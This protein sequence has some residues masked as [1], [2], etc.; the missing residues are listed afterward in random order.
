MT[1]RE[2]LERK[3]D[4][5]MEWAESRENK[6]KSEWSKGDLSESA[7]GIPFG[8]PILVGHH[9]EGRHRR[10][11]DRANRAM[12]RAVENESMADHH[13]SKAAGLE[14]MLGKTIFSDDLDAVEALEARI[15]GHEAER[16]RNNTINKIIRKKPRAEKTPEKIQALV[17]LG[18][19]K[20]LAEKMFE[21][22][23]MNDIGIPAYVNQNLGGRIKADRDRLKRIRRTA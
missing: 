9:S 8:Q 15:A 3:A 2:R 18:L 5:R 21:P 19:S 6:A 16:T 4:R 23:C 11:V 22:D 12:D 1:R 17:D 7:T 14:S 20:A 13:R 10:T